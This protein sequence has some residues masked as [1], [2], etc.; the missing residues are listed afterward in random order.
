L[1]SRARPQ[2]ALWLW[3]PKEI[4]GFQ[5]GASA[6]WLSARGEMPGSLTSVFSEP[7]DYEAALRE[8]ACPGLLVTGS[9]AFR[10]RLT[11]IAL[12]HLRL[13]AGEEH[14]SRI[15]LVAVPPG[16]ILIAL[17]GTG[18]RAPVL[19]GIS[20][21][22]RDI[23]TLGPGERLHLRSYGRYRWGAIWVPA[24]H[25]ARYGGALTGTVF[26]VPSAALRWR[27]RPAISTHLRRLHSAAI[28]FVERRSKVRFEGETAHGLEQQLIE[29]VIDCLAKGP[30]IEAA[31]PTR[32]HQDV[33]L[34]F[35]SLLE[36]QPERAFRITEICAA[37][38]VPARTLRLSCEEQLGMAATEYI[39]RR[40][41]QLVRRA[42]S[43]GNPDAPSIAKLVRQ[44]DF[45]GLGRFAAEYRAVYGE[46]PSA[47][48]RRGLRGFPELALRGPNAKFL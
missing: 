2:P 20:M 41:M 31:L 10:A 23:M 9:G 45:R 33:V 47:T 43:R 46:P 4:H 21:G 29:A 40:R 34:R 24:V 32:G 6:P 1:N 8:W 11:R 17:P 5:I 22:P 39:R 16:M 36:A 30:A 18:E 25:L 15:M 44:H 7:E 38:G 28:G 37:L 26:A 27:P 14:L 13:S 42:L 3:Q 35:E 48:L 12:H 19:G